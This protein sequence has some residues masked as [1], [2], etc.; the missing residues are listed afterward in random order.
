MQSD[1]QDPS[2]SSEFVSANA[3]MIW[4]LPRGAGLHRCILREGGLEEPAI[5]QSRAIYLVICSSMAAILT[6]Q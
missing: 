3:V 6:E 2:F 4:A 5:P 1:I